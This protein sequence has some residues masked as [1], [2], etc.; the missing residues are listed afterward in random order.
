[1]NCLPPSRLTRRREPRRD[2][3]A[4]ARG[5]PARCHQYRPL[6][7]IQ[8]LTRVRAMPGPDS[9]FCMPAGSPDAPGRLLLVAGGQARASRHR[10]RRRPAVRQQPIIEESS[11]M[12]D[13]RFAIALLS[14]V[15]A[16]VLVF[17]MYG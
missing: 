9:P 16:L 11:T 8:N 14:F 15:G 5:G 10:V 1:M 7:T 13:P 3:G 4:A 12:R 2:G 6:L 17:V